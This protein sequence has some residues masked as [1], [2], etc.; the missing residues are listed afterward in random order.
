LERFYGG[1][2]E[3]GAALGPILYQL[4]PSLKRDT[5][6]LERFAERLPRDL[7]HVFEFRDPG[8]FEDDVRG[9]LKKWN[10]AFC[11]HD[12]HGLRV[13]HWVTGPLAYWRFHGYSRQP[14]GNYTKSALLAAAGEMQ[15]QIAQK[16]AVYAYFN[17]DAYGCAVQDAQ[18]LIAM[19]VE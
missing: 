12:H 19:I 8:W 16:R 7:M 18:R 11:I 1:V 3:L 10:L 2:R 6:R 9:L 5:A 14:L 15:A 4:P 13:P 17:N